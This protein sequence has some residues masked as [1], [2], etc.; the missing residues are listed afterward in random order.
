[1]LQHTVEE[2]FQS[3]ARREL[4]DCVYFLPTLF[5]FSQMQAS[6]DWWEELNEIWSIYY[7]SPWSRRSWEWFS[8]FKPIH[9]ACS[10]LEMCSTAVML[11]PVEDYNCPR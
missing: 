6:S 3:A 7:R 9:I 1:M 11:C 2:Q 4:A 8:E 5:S 10:V